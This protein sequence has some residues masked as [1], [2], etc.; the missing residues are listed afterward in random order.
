VAISEMISVVGGRMDTFDF[1]TG[2]HVVYDAK[3]DKWEAARALYVYAD[4]SDHTGDA[5]A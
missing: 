5:S 2:M 1:N 3:S 4:R